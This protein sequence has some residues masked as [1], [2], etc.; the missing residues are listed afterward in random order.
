MHAFETVDPRVRKI[1]DSTWMDHEDRY[2]FETQRGGV[3]VF[4]LR[5]GPG[6]MPPLNEHP[7]DTLDNAIAAHL[8]ALAS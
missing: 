4:N 7:Y 2:V 5:K 1:G 3:N 6:Q 8:G